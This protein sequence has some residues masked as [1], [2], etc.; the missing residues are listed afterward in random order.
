MSEQPTHPTYQLPVAK[1]LTAGECK[2]TKVKHWKNYRQ[3]YGL[4]EADIP[5][6]IRMMT[7][8]DLW[9]SE[10]LLKGY[11][12]VHAWRA[13]GQLKAVEAIA[14]LLSLWD[15]YEDDDWL[16]NEAPSVFALIGVDALPILSNALAD[17]SLSEWARSAVIDGIEKIS[18]TEPE[19]RNTCVE[20]LRRQLEAFN[21]NG[22]I[23]N[24]M[25][26]STLVELKAVETIDLIEQVYA[27]QKIDDMIPGTWPHIQVEFGLKQVSDF[28]PAELQP[29]F[30]RNMQAARL[31][32]NPKFEDD[33]DELPARDWHETSV[34]PSGFGEGFLE[35]PKQSPIKPVQ[36][37]GQGASTKGNKKKK[38]L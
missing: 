27:A 21:D 23:V 16:S 9:A 7:D 10:E 24:G 33:L 3:K 17:L 19:Y 31:I 13:L 5:E 38:K 35:V 8:A 25:I 29:Q 37:F 18:N 11:S 20:I 6:L 12:V 22:L 2:L 34:T 32:R 1:L 28:T 30:F 36:G 4:T 15:D 14:P 26:V